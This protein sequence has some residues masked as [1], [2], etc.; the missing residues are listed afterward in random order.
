MVQ[1]IDN[2]ETNLAGQLLLEGARE[3]L[4]TD[5][6]Q[7]ITRSNPP[8]TEEHWKLEEAVSFLGVLEKMYGETGGHGLAQRIG[9]AAFRY[10]MHEVG[11]QIGFRTLTFRLLPAPRRVENGLQRLARLVS[12]ACGSTVTVTDAGA[13][14]VWHSSGCSTCQQNACVGSCCHL[15]VGLLQEFASWASGGRYF[16]VTESQCQANGASACV[17]QVE[18][19]PLD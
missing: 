8:F 19:K 6:I 12:H 15:M 9:R 16:R 18:K 3:L 17:F 2:Y 11:D 5:Y 4:G 10:G 13:A 1:L 14:W 7:Q